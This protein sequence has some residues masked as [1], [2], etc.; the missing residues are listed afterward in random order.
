MRLVTDGYNASF[1]GLI[2]CFEESSVM[3]F[4]VA[5]GDKAGPSPVTFDKVKE[6][7]S[8][9]NGIKGLGENFEKIGHYPIREHLMSCGDGLKFMH[10][11]SNGV[12]GDI[13][14][15]CGVGSILYWMRAVG[16]R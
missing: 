2:E 8:V 1:L 11:R 4:S 14:M 16:I 3:S 13:C 10:R 6:K 5:F 7:F 9:E 15:Y 12:G